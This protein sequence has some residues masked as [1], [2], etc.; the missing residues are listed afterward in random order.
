MVAGFHKIWKEQCKAAL[1]IREDFGVQKALGYLIGEKLINFLR[2]S[3]ECGD[4]AQELPEFV[5]WIRENFD[6]GDIRDYL[7]SVRRVGA[8]GHAVTE[9]DVEI[10]KRAGFIEEN[11]E[12]AAQDLELLQRVKFLLID[13]GVVN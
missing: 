11:A 3:D 1:G 12:Q 10:L 7:I 6:S 8:L 5:S 2:E 13:E 9:E 4:F